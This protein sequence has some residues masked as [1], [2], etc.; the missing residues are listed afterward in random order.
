M[1]Y[2]YLPQ[3]RF[4]YRE[5]LKFIMLMKLSFLVVFITCLNVSASV[6]SQEKI[7]L[8]VKKA[9][10]SRVLRLIEEQSKYRFAYSSNYV[11]V[12]KDVS[13]KVTKAYLKINNLESKIPENFSGIF[14]FSSSIGIQ[15]SF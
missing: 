8:D 5:L 9:K 7:S 4:R 10:L 14:M 11:P 12:N 15:Q 13:I 3:E 6:F 1:I 2:Y